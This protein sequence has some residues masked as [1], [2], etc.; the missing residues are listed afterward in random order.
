MC[1]RIQRVAQARIASKACRWRRAPS[2]HRQLFG[3]GQGYSQWPI[4]KFLG[5]AVE[6]SEHLSRRAS[7]GK[8]VIGEVD[9]K[10]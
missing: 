7:L 2:I 10:L 3:G 9:Q 5:G 4:V 6:I 1:Q 8:E